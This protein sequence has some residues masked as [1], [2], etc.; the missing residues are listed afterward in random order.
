MIKMKEV[1]NEVVE[2]VIKSCEFHIKKY[3]H[4]KMSLK[5]LDKPIKKGKH[6]LKKVFNKKVKN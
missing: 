1:K 5:E 6:T 3:G 4:R 2:D